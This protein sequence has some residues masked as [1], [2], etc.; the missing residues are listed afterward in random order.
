MATITYIGYKSNIVIRDFVQSSGHL[1][2]IHLLPYVSPK[3]IFEASEY[4]FISLYAVNQI[5]LKKSNAVI[6]FQELKP[7][8]HIGLCGFGKSNKIVCFFFS[9]LYSN[10]LTVGKRATL[11]DV[12]NSM[13]RKTIFVGGN[14][15]LSGAVGTPIS[16]HKSRRA[17]TCC[18]HFPLLLAMIRKSSR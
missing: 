4:I 15:V 6:L 12:S 5:C 9:W 10:N 1:A 3:P 11:N 14:V 8:G 7:Y 17:C 16:S 13:P 2:W 18:W